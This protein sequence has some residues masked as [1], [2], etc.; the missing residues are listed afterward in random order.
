MNLKHSEHDE[1]IEQEMTDLADL[2]KITEIAID[3]I[4]DDKKKNSD[5]WY[6]G[7]IK[8]RSYDDKKNTRN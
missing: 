3:N 1:H 4:K 7:F 2:A 6:F 8:S 5:D